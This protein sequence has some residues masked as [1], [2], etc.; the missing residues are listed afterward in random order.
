MQIFILS[1]IFDKCL[2]NIVMA[3]GLAQ[4][5]FLLALLAQPH[6]LLAHHQ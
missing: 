4:P 6:F 2:P 3:R 1:I 5:H